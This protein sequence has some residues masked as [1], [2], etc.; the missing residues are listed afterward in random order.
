MFGL[1]P[2]RLRVANP[3]RAVDSPHPYIVDVQRRSA[4]GTSLRNDCVSAAREN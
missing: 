4:T 2:A 1:V 3:E